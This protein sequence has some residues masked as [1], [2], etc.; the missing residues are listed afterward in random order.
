MIPYTVSAI[1]F[2]T[3]WDLSKTLIAFDH[4]YLYQQTPAQDGQSLFKD[5]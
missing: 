1:A 4:S 2:E 5:V 3:I